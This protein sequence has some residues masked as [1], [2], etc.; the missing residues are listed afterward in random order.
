MDGTKVT[1]FERGLRHQLT[2][3]NTKMPAPAFS[4]QTPDEMFFETGT[5]VSE[6]LT[7]AK[8]HARAARVAANRTMSCDCC[9]G[10]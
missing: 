5:K 3:H 7:V 8:T 1:G 10:R 9:L 6:E 2:E 4:G